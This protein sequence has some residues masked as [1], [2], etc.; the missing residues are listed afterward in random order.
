MSEYKDFCKMLHVVRSDS[1]FRGTWGRGYSE[2]EARK[3]ASLRKKDAYTYFIFK[4]DEWDI[5]DMGV[6]TWNNGG[7]AYMVERNQAKNEL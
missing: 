5:T 7:L 4:D 1:G 6:V 3:N 2:E